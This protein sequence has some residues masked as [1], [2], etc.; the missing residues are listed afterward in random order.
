MNYLKLVLLFFTC[1]CLQ[2]TPARSET[3]NTNYSLNGLLQTGI[4]QIEQNNCEQARQTLSKI[5]DKYPEI[6]INFIKNKQ[7]DRFNQIEKLIQSA[8]LNR[9]LAAYRL[10]DYASALGDFE[11][12]KKISPWQ[13]EPYYNMGLAW[14]SKGEYTQAIAQYNVA[15]T[16]VSPQDKAKIATIYND[17]GL[18][19]LNLQNFTA[20]ISDFDLG[21]RYQEN[22]PWLHYNRGCACHRHGNY[23]AAIDSFSEALAVNP[24][25]AEAYVNRG[26]IHYHLGRIQIA[27]D[28]LNAGAK[29]FYSQGKIADFEKARELIKQMQGKIADLPSV[30]A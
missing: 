8:Y 6:S 2:F 26:L 29:S 24:Q 12:A 3:L 11:R 18:A 20:A 5:I 10:G 30:A 22:N 1:W 4:V 7:S 14:S 15:L 27:L 21:I 28:D 17:R 9:G 23:A 16:Q 19:N 13:V 25:Q